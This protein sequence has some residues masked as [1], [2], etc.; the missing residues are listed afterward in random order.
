MK[1][2]TYKAPMIMGYCPRCKRR[3][4]SAHIDHPEEYARDEICAICGALK[5][6]TL[7]K[8]ETPAMLKVATVLRIIEGVALLV[9]LI[10]MWFVDGKGLPVGLVAVVVGASCFVGEVVLYRNVPKQYCD[11][12]ERWNH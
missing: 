12:D 3:T 6:T 10:S 2:K 9:A 5:S 1:Q 11:I 4:L 7:M 8:E